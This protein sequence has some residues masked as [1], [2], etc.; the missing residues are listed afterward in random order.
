[1]K[2]LAGSWVAV[3]LVLLILGALAPRLIELGHALLPLV[4]VL[5]IAAVVLRLTFFH[6][7]KW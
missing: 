6:T 4:V 5:T 7:R 3:V 2:A 1:M